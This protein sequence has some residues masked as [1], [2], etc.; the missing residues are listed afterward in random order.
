M[1]RRESSITTAGTLIG[2]ALPR[3]RLGRR[4]AF[5][6]RAHVKSS[7]NLA[8]GRLSSGVLSVTDLS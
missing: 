4:L 3:F 6:N 7:R 5:Y 8:A 2:G 1:R